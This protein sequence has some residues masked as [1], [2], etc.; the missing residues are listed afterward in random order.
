MNFKEKSQLKNIS[1]KY[2]LS[3]IILFGSYVNDTISDKSDIDI[4]VWVANGKIVEETEEEI[5]S[6]FIN[7]LKR[8]KI[9]LVI[10]NYADPLLQF[11]VASK[12]MV[13]YESRKGEFNRFQVFA[14]KRNDDGKKFYTLNKAY[15]ENFLK[16]KRSD[17]KRRCHPPQ[18][19][20]YS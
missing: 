10:L 20:R 8:D 4:G 1:K 15:L 6:A 11:E 12:G 16:G 3:L 18:I 17:V 14:M 2:G 9:D 7:L 13:L 19:S 5:F